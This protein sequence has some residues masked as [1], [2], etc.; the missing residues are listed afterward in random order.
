MFIVEGGPM[1]D[2]KLKAVARSMELKFYLEHEDTQRGIPCMKT[3]EVCLDPR[4]D[5]FHAADW[6]KAARE[7]LEEYQKRIAELEAK[8]KEHENQS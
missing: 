1:T 3:G 5:F 4:H 7:K 6:L 2:D 8:L